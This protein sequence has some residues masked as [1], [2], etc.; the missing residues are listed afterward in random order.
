MYLSQQLV[1]II[2]SPVCQSL[3]AILLIKVSPLIALKK[4]SYKKQLKGG[5]NKKGP[6]ARQNGATG[7]PMV[8]LDARGR[9]RR[10]RRKSGW[11]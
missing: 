8:L 2:V 7:L 1:L 4:A 10:T 3:V 5:D 9:W 6:K 11:R